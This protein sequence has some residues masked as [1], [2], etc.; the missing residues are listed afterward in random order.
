MSFLGDWDDILESLEVHKKTYGGSSIGGSAAL[1]ASGK[2][3]RFPDEASANKIIASFEERAKSMT[4]RRDLIFDARQSLSERFSDDDVSDGYR[5]KALNSLAA[6][7]E[8]NSSALKYAEN[9]VRKIEAVKAKKLA[10]DAEVGSD[11]HK[12]ARALL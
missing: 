9:Y 12:I 5:E 4:K 7:E 3:F 1:T 2:G 8:L 11:A 6:L 10:E